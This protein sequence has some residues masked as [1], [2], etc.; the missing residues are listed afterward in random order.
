MNKQ[1][2]P[3]LLIVG[4]GRSG[5]TS[6]VEYLNQHPDIFMFRHLSV[7]GQ[8]E[9]KFFVKEVINSISDLDPLKKGILKYSVLDEKKY[10]E[11]FKTDRDYKVYGE[12]SIHYFNH[13]EISIKN[14]HEFLGD[15][16]IIIILRNPV[17]KLISN[18]KYIGSDIYPLDLSLE[19]EELRK[20]FGYNSFW[21]YKDQ[22]YYYNRVKKF[23]SNFSKVKILILEE[24][25]KQPN[26]FLNECA[27]FLSLKNYDFKIDKVFN[28]SKE[29]FYF[30][31]KY[32]QNYLKNPSTFKY[33]SNL[34]IKTRLYKKKLF[35]VEKKSD[36]KINKKK[37][38][39]Y[40]ADD[41]QKVERLLNKNLTIWKY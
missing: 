16:P 17:E 11:L 1:K 25:T 29:N 18:W 40:F 34:Y 14:I 39:N 23:L 2:K 15:I 24:F 9:P 19:M 6:L 12:A 30:K 35:F 21:L 38:Y 20:K 3:N 27:N 37:I 7:A 5:T 4:A 36:Y 41:I 22:S 31:K 10:F 33:I 26:K 28:E 32:I 13:P 8:N